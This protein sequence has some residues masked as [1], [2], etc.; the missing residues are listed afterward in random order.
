MRALVIIALVVLS[1]CAPRGRLDYHPDREAPARA[2]FVGSTR[3]DL[4]H[5]ESPEAFGRSEALQL[6]RFDVSVPPMHQPGEITYPSAQEAPDPQT[7]FLVSRAAIYARPADFRADLRRELARNG[8]EAIV[9]VHGYNTTFVEGLYRLAQL[10]N[11]FDLPGVLVHYSWPSRG[12]L[13]GYAYDH[14]SALFARDGFEEFLRELR[15]A[16]ARSILI[17]GHS[18]GAALTMES[19]RQIA[20]SGE[21]ETISRLAGVV[22]ISPDIDVDVFR[23][24]ARRIGKLPQ[25]FLIFTSQRDKALGLSSHINGDQARLGNL[26]D[27]EQVADLK[28]TIVDVG[29]F[30]TGEGHFNVATSPALIALLGE[31][32]RAAAVL[33]GDQSEHRNLFSGVVL[34]VQNVTQIILAPVEALAN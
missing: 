25:P 31:N 33:E 32:G 24:Q 10:G 17:V 19:L 12:H 29:A 1:A 9:F 34:S 22:L 3:A 16:G 18:M 13:M 20:I 28:L 15:A 23:A 11:D 4:R 27:V 14:D 5:P 8:G 6:G 7:D 2:I 30:S 26:Q 21:T